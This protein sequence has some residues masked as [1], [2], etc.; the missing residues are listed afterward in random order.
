MVY[1]LKFKHCAYKVNLPILYVFESD[2]KLCQQSFTIFNLSVIMM[3]GIYNIYIYTF[4][5]AIFKMI[6]VFP[7]NKE[8]KQSEH[9]YVVNKATSNECSCI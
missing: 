1:L 6:G 9:E 5:K 2:D 7:I 4:R 3:G 8:P